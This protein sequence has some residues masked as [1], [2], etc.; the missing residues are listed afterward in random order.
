MHFVLPFA[1]LLRSKVRTKRYNEKDASTLGNDIFNSD[2]KRVEE[3][4]VLDVALQRERERERTL[5]Q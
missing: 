5:D 3:H 2:E 1:N 4:Q